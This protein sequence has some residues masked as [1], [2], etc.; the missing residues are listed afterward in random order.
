MNSTTDP[1]AEQNSPDP[2]KEKRRLECKKSRTIDEF[3]NDRVQFKIGLYFCKAK[4]HRFRHYLFSCIIAISAAFV[5]VLINLKKNEDDFDFILIATFFSVLVSIGV[6]LQEIFHFRE[7]WRNYDLIDANLRS[8][9]MLF[10]MKAGP[11]E[12]CKDDEERNKLFVERI[13]D[14]IKNERA[15]TI[16]MRTSGEWVSENKKLFETMIEDYLR[17]KKL[18][19]NRDKKRDEN[20]A[21]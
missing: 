10:S 6:A 16:N 11:Y 19:P 21:E 5:P 17:E 18:I 13:E 12:K 20:S 2:C 1:Q 8:E 15:E 4:R 7:H 14:L 9:E 3:I